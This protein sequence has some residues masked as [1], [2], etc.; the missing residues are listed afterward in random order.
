MW[1][2][3]GGEL[4]FVSDRDGTENLWQQSLDGGD[5][6]QITAF[7][8]GRLFRPT[9]SPDGAAVVFEREF[10]LWRADTRTGECA[11]LEIRVHADTT[12]TPVTPSASVTRGFG[13]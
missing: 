5:A 10:G 6:R 11:P 4:L 12:P 1:A 13:P 7:K 2:P 9:L 8:D 3:G